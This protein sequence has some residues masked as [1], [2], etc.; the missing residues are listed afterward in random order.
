MANP[1][2][3]HNN[4]KHRCNNDQSNNYSQYNQLNSFNNQSNSLFPGYAQNDNRQIPHG[5]HS[6]SF[7]ATYS[8]FEKEKTIKEMSDKIKELQKSQAQVILNFQEQQPEGQKQIGICDNSEEDSGA[9]Y[10]A[11]VVVN[12]LIK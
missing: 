4:Q 3:Q 12:V 9:E 2:N 11:P 10:D 8:S 1:H 5:F 6:A 7:E